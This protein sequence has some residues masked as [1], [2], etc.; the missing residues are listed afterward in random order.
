M[1]LEEYRREFLTL[2]RVAAESDREGTVT[3][4][5]GQT[6]N[7]LLDAGVIPDYEIC[8]YTGTGRRNRRFR[9]DGY[10]LD[11]FDMTMYLLI[12]D[13][14]GSDEPETLTMTQARTVFDRLY[15][16][17]DEALTG[18]LYKEM[19]IST[20]AYDLVENIKSNQSRMRK[21]SFILL[22]DKIA[23]ER[24]ETLKSSEIQG[25]LVEYHLWDMNR[26]FRVM[27]SE[28]GRDEIFINFEE[29]I[30]GGLP[31][32]EASSAQ[33][34]EYRSFLCVISGNVLADIYDHYGSRLLEG[35][36]R[37][38]LST[39]KAVNKKIRET[40]LRQPK[41]F[42]AYNNGISATAT[43]VV[44]EQQING[45]AIS[46]VRG[47]QIVNGGQT[48]ASISNARYKD[49]VS[50]DN[51]YVQVKLTEVD[52]VLAS[53]IIPD[54][55][56]SSN[57]QNKVSEADFFSNHAFHIQ[58]EKMSRRIFAPAVGGAQYETHWFYERA[59]GQYLQEQSRMKKSEKNR[60]SM[61][62]PQKQ[63]MTK[64]DIAKVYNAWR[65]LP[66]KVS[67]GAQKNFAVFAEW[68]TEE[69]ERSNTRFNELFFK[70]CVALII[71]FKKINVS[72]RQQPWY[73]NGYLANLTAYSMAKLAYTLK[74]DIPDKEL[75]LMQIWDKQELPDI[76]CEQLIPIYRA[77]FEVLTD[78]TR[79][80]QNVTE[81]SK[82]NICWERTKEFPI[83]LHPQINELMMDKR[84][85]KT[86]ASSA[87]TEQRMISG[88][89]AQMFVVEKGPSYWLNILSWAGG[90]KLLSPEENRILSLAGNMS[91]TRM[92]N[93]VQC[94]I[95]QEI[96]NKVLAEG[97]L[98]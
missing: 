93:E 18:S 72:I 78:Q 45:L 2:V 69:W 80:V 96:R 39:K 28:S 89:E 83:H 5:V 21:Y 65:G 84:E 11:D 50:L 40:I 54:I 47:L 91:G 94:K 13:Y 51:I 53:S 12:A 3:S 79:P 71:L 30:S 14:S 63:K 73:E 52:P 20:P 24:I 36:V 66:Q 42:F 33:T 58:M 68:I 17:L 87:R 64:T 86:Q 6:A 74:K 82:N 9:V 92:P 98:D 57:S 61:M 1:E 88:I 62:N 8:F 34:D 44:V 31:C 85:A 19:E 7:S 97:Y 22:T 46:S 60:F 4:F 29:Y 76:L 56:R 38:F 27:E 70:Q 67:L 26:F 10:A 55:S 32:L 25:V 41:R 35:N 23:S 43:D 77:V 81:W 59:A 95:L 90:K 48:T 15:A 16:F 75:D 49:S 37:S